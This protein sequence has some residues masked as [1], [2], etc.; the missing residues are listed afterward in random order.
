MNITL[1]SGPL[2]DTGRIRKW[3]NENRH[4]IIYSVLV[5][6]VAYGYELF[7]FSLSI[8][9][10]YTSFADRTTWLSYLRIGRWGTYLL[11]QLFFSHSL[12]PWFPFLIG[13]ICLALSAVLLTS[14]IN[15]NFR[16]KILFITVFVTTPVHAYYLTFNTAAPFFGFA[17]L[18]MVISFLGLIR[19]LDENNRW[20]FFLSMPFFIFS[21]AIYQ[22][23]LAFFITLSV[24][25]LLSTLI[26]LPGVHYPQLIK[27]ASYLLLF[28]VIA[29]VFYQLTDFTF[30]F[31]YG[32]NT[33]ENQE[34]LD[35]YRRWGKTPVNDIFNTLVETTRSFITGKNLQVTRFG[36]VLTFQLL[37][38][39]LIMVF[40]IEKR[41]VLIKG[42]ILALLISL[43]FA[44]FSLMYLN[45]WHMPYRTMVALPLSMALVWW[46]LYTRVAA[47][48]KNILLA[49]CFFLLMSNTIAIT[50]LFH[51]TYVS[52]QADRDMANRIYERICSLESD[53]SGKT[54]AVV[55]VGIFE[56]AANPLFAKSEV[57][58]ASFFSWDRGSP[59]RIQPFFN[60]IG[61]ND[62]RIIPSEK[63]IKTQRDTL[64]KIP[65]WP[66]KGSVC[67][68]DTLVVVKLGKIRQP[69]KRGN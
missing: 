19:A 49:L 61:I 68:I 37:V 27:R 20:L 32:L 56:R 8:D 2:F 30:R 47:W 23:F 42:M 17:L 50:R 13:I 34:Y 31:F 33:P 46:L 16:A 12:L 40:F 36:M 48:G 69:L 43:L 55:F 59:Y 66:R 1:N 52:W 54:R 58:G 4:L 41:T 57:F 11:N 67:L 3:V 14:L 26:N 24:F 65:V 44:P 29:L 18:L 35:H 51:A 22:A 15:G 5:A 45:G 63:L 39:I 28:L 25:H 6:V 62:L 38:P 7:N 10:E 9:E 64:E 60:T 21:L 53:D